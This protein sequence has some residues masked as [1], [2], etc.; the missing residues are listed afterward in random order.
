MKNGLTL[1]HLPNCSREGKSPLDWPINGDIVFEVPSE[2]S[3]SDDNLPIHYMK[4]EVTPV[5]FHT[6]CKS[7]LLQKWL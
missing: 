7:F 1:G 3:S 6:K 2:P 5:Y 4:K